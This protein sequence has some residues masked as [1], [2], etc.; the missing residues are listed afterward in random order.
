MYDS[1]LLVIT[2]DMEILTILC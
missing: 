1:R 2:I